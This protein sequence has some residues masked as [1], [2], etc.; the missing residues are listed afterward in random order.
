M[1]VEKNIILFLFYVLES[2]P[3]IANLCFIPDLQKIIAF[4]EQNKVDLTKMG[5]HSL[6]KNRRTLNYH[7]SYFQFFLDHRVCPCL[8]PGPEFSI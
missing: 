8:Q 4:Q 7:G 6:K 5:Q 1:A 3:P 2:Y